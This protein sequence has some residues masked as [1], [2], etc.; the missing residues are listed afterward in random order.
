MSA[1]AGCRAPMRGLSLIEA[2][3]ALAVMAFGMVGVVGVQSTLRLNSDV[4]KQR[5]EAVRIAQEAMEQWRSFVAIDVPPASGLPGEPVPRSYSQIADIPATQATGYTTN[6]VYTLQGF[7]TELPEAS[8]KSVRVTVGWTDRTGQR[9]SVQLDS[10]VAR[11]EPSLTAGVL[12]QPPGGSA[13]RPLG[14]HASIPI[15]AHEIAPGLSVFKPPTSSRDSVAWVF[16]NVSGL[17]VGVCSVAAG[18]PASSLTQADIESCKDNTVAHLLAG[19]VRFAT[20]DTQPTAADAES[21]PSAVRNLDIRVVLTSTG[22]SGAVQCFDSAPIT[23]AARTASQTA[24]A[25]YCMIPANASRAWAGY[26][27]VVPLPF[28][29]VT[30]SEW[31][32][33]ANPPPALE[34]DH[35]LCRYTPASNDAE[36]VANGQ[37]PYVYKIVYADPV[38]RTGPQV[39]PPLIN[40]NFLVI[41]IVHSCPTDVPANPLTGDYVNSNTLVH[42]PIPAG[43]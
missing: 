16:D 41:R 4:A 40:Q 11:T 25:Y 29:D 14:R 34:P 21:P 28:D 36:P 23:M 32:L 3:V 1:R 9:Q 13:M 26:S 31:T 33:P 12:N 39:T 37:H 35:Q 20:L 10:L 7:V 24:V 18:V 15:E 6:T 8:A 2:L 43:P 17:I 42:L 22:H 5:S 30:G 38:R 19:Y 27:T